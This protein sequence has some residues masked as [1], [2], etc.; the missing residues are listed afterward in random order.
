MQ[1][2]PILIAMTNVTGEERD[3]EYNRWYNEVHAKDILALPTVSSITRYRGLQQIRPEIGEPSFR[4]LAIYEMDD[5]ERA[6]AALMAARPQMVMS[7]A[8]HSS[9]LAISYMPIFHER[10]R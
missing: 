9:P 7:D 8:L 6:I 5:P 1:Q 2:K 10:N 3:A 4:Y